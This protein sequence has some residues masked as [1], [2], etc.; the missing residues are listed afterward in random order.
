MKP[1]LKQIEELR[2]VLSLQYEAFAHAQSVSDLIS[3]NRALLIAVYDADQ[4]YR[5]ELAKLN[6]DKAELVRALRLL[7]DE[8]N[9]APTGWKRRARWELAMNECRITLQKF[10]P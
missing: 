6:A 10:D 5:R 3:D 2:D 1:E 8:Q 4:I 7:F 9:D